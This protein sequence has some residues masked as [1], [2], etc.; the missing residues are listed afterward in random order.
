MPA[1]AT[2]YR[3]EITARVQLAAENPTVAEL[4]ATFDKSGMSFAGV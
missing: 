1:I 3:R 4:T 2:E